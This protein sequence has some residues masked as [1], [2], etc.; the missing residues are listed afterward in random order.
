MFNPKTINDMKYLFSKKA[1]IIC[2]L[3]CVMAFGAINILLSD[4]PPEGL[5]CTNCDFVYRWCDATQSYLYRCV[6]G[7]EYCSVSNQPL[8]E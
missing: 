2:I 3:T 7:G 1:F 6:L 4:D 8:C 5:A